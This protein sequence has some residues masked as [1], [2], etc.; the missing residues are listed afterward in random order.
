[1]FFDLPVWFPNWE[2]GI[3]VARDHRR[4]DHDQC[5][6][7]SAAL[8]FALIAKFHVLAFVFRCHSSK[9]APNHA[10]FFDGGIYERVSCFL[11]CHLCDMIAN[12]LRYRKIIFNP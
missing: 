3:S 10:A 5:E 8:A 12:R 6:G 7:C 2:S 4:Y 1:M 11:I 9:A